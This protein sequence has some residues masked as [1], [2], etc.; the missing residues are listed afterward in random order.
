MILCCSVM[1]LKLLEFALK[2][3]SVH[4]EL[5]GA[6]DNQSSIDGILL[7]FEHGFVSAFDWGSEHGF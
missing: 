1:R 7:Y 4:L 3:Y 6:V 2:P 5:F